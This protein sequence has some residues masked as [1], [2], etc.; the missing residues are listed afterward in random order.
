VIDIVLLAALLLL[1]LAIYIAVRRK[2][3]AT[4]APK[5]IR[6]THDHADVAVSRSPDD[7]AFDAAFE[8]H[9][10]PRTDKFFNTKITGLWLP[11]AD[12]SD[13]T[14][15][16]KKCEPMELLRLEVEPNNPVDPKAIAVKRVDGSQ[17]GYLDF[18][19][20]SD[21]HRD[22]GNPVS[23]SAVFRHA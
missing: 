4:E 12:G 17:L 7:E 2:T 10:A 19:V 13:R 18:R 20:A 22:A 6:Q 23:W 3:A 9:I 8:R 21:L 15:V 1:S 16:I 14:S 11:N 5:P